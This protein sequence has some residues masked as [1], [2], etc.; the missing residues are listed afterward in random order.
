MGVLMTR[1]AARGNIVTHAHSA[2]A[3]PVDTNRGTAREGATGSGDDSWR[4]AK[5]ER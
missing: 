1:A 3:G 4:L 2:G 5:R